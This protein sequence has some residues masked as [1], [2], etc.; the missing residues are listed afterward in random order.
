MS[1]QHTIVTSLQKYI[2]DDLVLKHSLT[3][4][5]LTLKIDTVEDELDVQIQLP[6]HLKGKY[7][8]T[9]K[10]EK[11]E[12]SGDSFEMVLSNIMS[13]FEKKRDQFMAEY[14][15]NSEKFEEDDDE[16]EEHDLEMMDQQIEQDEED[17][18]QEPEY[19]ILDG[20]QLEQRQ[21]QGIEKVATI[22]GM[23]PS[24]ARVV[25][26]FYGWNIERILNKFQEH[27]KERVLKDAGL[28]E[29]YE[30][31][32]MDKN[33][34]FECPGCLDDVKIADTTALLCT[35]RFCNKCWKV[36]VGW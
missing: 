11:H 18:D 16:E 32:Q 9:F 33:A 27:G 12:F 2:D 3:E 19:E 14:G 34:V 29:D 13:I 28:Y 7:I 5:T 4:N 10:N 30:N 35:H 17:D 24:H 6:T 20:K 26:T 1:L 8:V 31:Q 22:L 21:K 25:L 36:I 15:E 23:S